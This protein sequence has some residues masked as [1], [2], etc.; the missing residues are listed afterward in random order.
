[1]G[2]EV[3]EAVAGGS[4]VSVGVD[5]GTT[6]VA[7]G[8]TGVAVGD[9][10]VAVAGAKVGVGGEGVRVGGDLGGGT[11]EGASVGATCATLDAGGATDW[12]AVN[13][14]AITTQTRTGNFIA[15]PSLD[16]KA[17]T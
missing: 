2:V 4:R 9:I 5:V 11:G 10:S 17:Q 13:W 6:G 16:V 14:I 3:R 1:L 15:P 8:G 7:V 12:H